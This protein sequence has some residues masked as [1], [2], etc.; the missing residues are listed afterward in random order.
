M[1]RSQRVM[2]PMAAAA[3]LL[4]S[5]C[6]TTST[7]TDTMQT[8]L[9]DI[10]AQM[11]LLQKEHTEL[12]S[13]IA[14]QV[15]LI[16]Q[17]LEQEDDGQ[18][19]ERAEMITRLDSMRDEM[20]IL[21]Q[22]L[23]DTNFRLSAL[24]G[25]IQ[26]TRNMF[27]YGQAPASGATDA[28]AGEAAPEEATTAEPWVPTPSEHPSGQPVTGGAS[29]QEIYNTAYADYTKGNYP[30]AILGFQEY[31]E[32]FPTSE[33]ADDALYWVGES[34]YSQEKYGDAV[35]AFEEVLAR[36]PRGDKVPAAHLK[37][38]LAFLESNRTA[39]G[40]V[41]LS[42]L[43]E[44]YPHTDEARLARERLRGMGLRDR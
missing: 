32:A 33:F 18:R 10:Q 4:F 42:A 36:Y 11:L 26:A 22:K 6:L 38:G 17:L 3:L 19:L 43:I 9:E 12:R 44:N 24:S 41:Q 31:L 5:A 28:A 30:L 29:P 20:S 21:L 16:R 1:S 8:D 37:K 2:V 40:V 7:H 27:S 25:D 14:S 39:Q 13:Q 35:A 34:Y 23:E 15:E